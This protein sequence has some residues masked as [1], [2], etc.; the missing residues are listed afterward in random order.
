[1][2]PPD[3]RSFALGSAALFVPMLGLVWAADRKPAL[4]QGGSLGILDEEIDEIAQGVVDR[5]Y[6]KFKE[7]VDEDL[8]GVVDTA[9]ERAINTARDRLPDVVD[10]AFSDVR[11]QNRLNA[12]RK[13]AYTVG[14]FVVVSTAI[15]TS[16]LTYQ[17]LKKRALCKRCRVWDRREE[18]L[19]VATIRQTL[20]GS[21]THSW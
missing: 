10:E 17:F 14:A 8:P 1:M 2:C 19:Y 6:P 5:V 16:F 11:V 18:R 4:R 13:E 12:G 21:I 7:K 15:L 9:T 3:F 20:R